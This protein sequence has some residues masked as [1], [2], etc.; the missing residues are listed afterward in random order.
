MQYNQALLA[1][2]AW[3]ILKNPTSLISRVL[4]ARYFTNTNFLESREGSCPSLTWR[5]IY[6]GKSLLI[7]GLR[8][9]IGN[10]QNTN[11]T[12]DPWIPRPPSF[13]PITQGLNS[14]RRVSELIQEPGKW[15]SVLIEQ[16]Y[17]SPD[18]Q[19]I[20]TLSLSPFDHVDSWLWHYNKNGNYSVDTS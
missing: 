17:M 15:N 12:K 4:Q 13:L 19:L 14:D 7:K 16:M 11:A 3:R 20:L 9:R 10:G 5:S 6:W 18:S 8:R 1:K 2:Q